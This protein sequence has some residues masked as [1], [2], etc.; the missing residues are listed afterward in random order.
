ML[1]NEDI[2]G[3]GNGGVEGT[4]AVIGAGADKVGENVVFI[5]SA[6]QAVLPADPFSWRN[7][8][9]ECRRK[10]PVGTTKID[11][12]AL[13]INFAAVHQLAVGGEIVDNLRQQTSPVDGSWRWRTSWLCCASVSCITE[14]VKIC[15]TAVWASSKLP[16]MA[17]T[18]TLPPSCVTIWRFCMGLT[19]FWGIEHQHAGA[20]YILEAFQCGFAGV[21]GS[22]HQNH[23]GFARGSF[24]QRF[25]QQMGQNLGEPYP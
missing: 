23:S 3:R 11:L 2:H 21:A 19:P 18:P 7:R 1:G 13:I 9:P 10:L 5:G 15:L 24:G 14:S 8:R 22:G 4:A 16:S 17:Q 6:D 25:Y 20:V 12:L